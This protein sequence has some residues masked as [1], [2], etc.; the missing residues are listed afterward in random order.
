[1]RDNEIVAAIV[2]SDLDGL[3]EAYDKYAAGLY[4]YCRSLLREPADAADAV[5]DTFVIAAAKAAELR[6]PDRL[7]PWLFAVARSECHRR[8]RAGN[9]SAMLEETAYVVDESADVSHQAE[10]AQLRE[11]VHAAITGLNPGEQEVIQLTLRHELHGDDLA[12]ALGVPRNHA[13]A[14][15]SR[16]RQQL[17]TSLGALLV[18]RGGRQSCPALDELLHGWD[19]TMTVLTRKRI[20]R[21]IERCEVCGKRKRLELRPAMLLGLAAPLAMLPSGLRDRVLALCMDGT[22]AAMVQRTGIVQRAGSTGSAGFPAP[23]DPPKAARWQPR[24]PKAARWQPSHHQMAATAGAVTVA[25]AAIAVVTVLATG[26]AHG[27]HPAG[28]SA[29][30]PGGPAGPSAPAVPPSSPGARH[31]AGP[32]P[33]SARGGTLPPGTAGSSGIRGAALGTGAIGAIGAGGTG[34]GTGAGGSGSGS[35]AGGGSAGGSAGTGGGGSGSGTGSSPA[36]VTVNGP[37]S[38]SPSLL[39]LASVLGGP[40]S[41]TLT[42]TAGSVPVTHYTISVPSSLAGELSV[43]PASGS[44]GAGQSTQ[45]TVTLSGLLSIDTTITV[46]PGGHSVHVLL[47]A[48]VAVTR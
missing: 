48:S 28:H 35:A 22:P 15:L 17:S 47:G 33:V 32:L 37:V 39:V 31:G 40:A 46:N 12:D 7:R 38:V 21:H 1:M 45:V 43:S 25:A 16:A 14:L 20:N 29:A 42:L 26:G 18:A 44:I 36:P 3:A 13:H 2:A 4:G 8:L 24:P 9:A 11:L 5:Q 41:G 6:D 30:G 10:R 23:L 34:A 27:R 19:G